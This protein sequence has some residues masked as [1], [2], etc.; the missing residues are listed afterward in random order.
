MTEAKEK[1]ADTAVEEEPA[2]ESKPA[3]DG[4]MA[5]F[6]DWVEGISVIELS[7]LVKTLEDRLGVTA[8]A[9]VAV[10]AG[11][12]G[13]EFRADLLSGQGVR[14]RHAVPGAGPGSALRG[15]AGR[16]RD[17]VPVRAGGRRGAA[18]PGRVSGSAA[19]LG[20]QSAGRRRGAARGGVHARCRKRQ[21]AM[22]VRW[23]TPP[24]L[25]KMQSLAAVCHTAA[26]ERQSLKCGGHFHRRTKCKSPICPQSCRP[27]GVP[28]L[29]LSGTGHAS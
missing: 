10:A 4:K 6:V 12:A 21:F 24:A 27:Q 16:G 25:G 18:V 2:K 8:A 26:P 9:P 15:G 13:R 22:C 7:E 19:Q 5:E 20:G 17:R 29:R 14:R 23:G 1:K 11:V 3:A 28:A